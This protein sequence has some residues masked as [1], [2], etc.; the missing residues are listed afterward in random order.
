M[1]A[2]FTLKHDCWKCHQCYVCLSVLDV[3]SA[4]RRDHRHVSSHY[5]RSSFYVHDR[6]PTGLMRNKGETPEHQNIDKRATISRKEFHCQTPPFDGAPRPPL[7]IIET[8]LAMALTFFALEIPN[9]V[10]TCRNV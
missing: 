5:S 6:H 8:Q 4:R 9:K 3:S 1:T 10:I 2:H 7:V